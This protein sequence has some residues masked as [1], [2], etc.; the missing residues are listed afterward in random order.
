M[1][2]TEIDEKTFNDYSLSHGGM[3]YQ[4][5]YWAKLKGAYGW[6]HY[7]LGLYDNDKLLAATLVL[8][9]KTPVF[10]RYLY[11]AP[12]GFLLDYSDLDLL[13]TF[14]NEVKK[15]LLKKKAFLIKINPY[16]R[17]QERDIEGNIVE[18]GFNNKKVVDKLLS[19]GYRHNGFTTTFG[20]D[21]EPRF[22]SVLDIEGKTYEELEANIKHKVKNKI[23]NSYSHGFELVVCNR[24]Q[25]KDFKALMADTAKRRGF[26]D[27]SLDYYETM[28]DVF[29]DDI[30]IVLAR[31]D[32]VKY[33]KILEDKIADD[34][35]TIDELLERNNKSALKKVDEYNKLIENSRSRL[36]EVEGYIEEYGESIDISGGLYLTYGDEMVS[37]FG[38]SLKRFMKYNPQ[39]F[40]KV[41]MIKMAVDMKK[42]RFNFFGMEGDFDLNSADS[43]LYEFKKAFGA[44]PWE[45]IGEFDLVVKPLFNSFYEL[46]YKIYQKLR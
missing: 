28:Y 37:L 8:G 27:R 46:I 30:K 23:R 6:C 16:V 25:I 36:K 43:G 24:D 29:D 19:L 3:F 40:L 34:L 9:R 26:I 14:S 35:K 2:L 18:N 42:K 44:K 33:K 22:L 13:E 32:L 4:S 41:E 21:L 10:N 45:L 38:S 12:R 1:H 11:Y 20:T 7:Y 39:T 17:Y 15:Y 31:W 5:V